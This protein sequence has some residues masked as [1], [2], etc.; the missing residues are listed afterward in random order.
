MAR[1]KRT[2]FWGKDENDD[3]LVVQILEGKKTASACPAEEYHLADGEY[4]DGGF[5]EGDLVEVYDLRK[6]FRCLI[7]ITEVYATTF[8]CFPDKLWKG[9]GNKS[10][11]QFRI[12][13]R[14]CWSDHQIDNEFE[15]MIHHF[16]LVRET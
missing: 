8:G 5:E 1:L 9:E 15:M 13:H 2:Q 10:A 14:S 6:R 12:D 7:R 3:G 11:E 16:E 4:E